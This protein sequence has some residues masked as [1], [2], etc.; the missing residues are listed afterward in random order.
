LPQEKDSG[1]RGN[2]SADDETDSTGEPTVVDATGGAARRSTVA[3]RFDPSQ[4]NLSGQRPNFNPAQLT[5][6]EVLNTLLDSLRDDLKDDQEMQQLVASTATAATVALT[7]GYAI[8]AL[9]SGHLLASLL[10]SM[11]VWNHF[12]PLPIVSDERNRREDDES[13]VDIANN[14]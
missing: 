11:P 12:D 13:L 14:R 7:A 6:A 10:A 8:W 3:V 5:E 2:R 1:G 4:G 9:K